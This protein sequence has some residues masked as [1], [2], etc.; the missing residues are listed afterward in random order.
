MNYPDCYLHVEECRSGQ[1]WIVPIAENDTINLKTQ[2]QRWI[3]SEFAGE[4]AL[5]SELI[6]KLDGDYY[7]RIMT[8]GRPPDSVVCWTGGGFYLKASY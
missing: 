3:A 7:A 1:S 5:A 8:D 4:L 6:P 2:V